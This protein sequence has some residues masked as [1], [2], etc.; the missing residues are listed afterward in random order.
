M[1]NAQTLRNHVR[2][3]FA[4][5]A[6][7][8]CHLQISHDLDAS[9]QRIDAHKLILARSPTLSRLINGATSASGSRMQLDVH[10]P[11]KYMSLHAFNECLKYIYGGQLPPLDPPYRQSFSF[12]EPAAAQ[13]ERMERALQR[14]AT[15]TWLEMPS[16]T[17][18]G[19]DVAINAM[20]W[21]TLPIALEFGL[22]G[23]LSPMWTLD[24]GS[25]ERGSTTSSDDSS[26]RTD[27]TP[28]M[29]AYDP[30][31]TQLLKVVLQYV[32]NSFP[33]DFYPDVSAP[34]LAVHPRLPP[35]PPLEP[36]NQNAQHEKNKL[37]RSAD[38]RLSQIRFGELPS[39]QDTPSRPSPLTTGI[40]S[41]LFSSPFPLLKFLLEHPLLAE[42]IGP[43]TVGSI[44]RQT[45]LERES[46]RLRCLK[47]KELSGDAAQDK[48][49]NSAELFWEESV[50]PTG[51]NRLGLR[52]CR[53]KKGV[54]TPPSS[55]EGTVNA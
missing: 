46:R 32:S 47:A 17:S 38:P 20:S 21:D 52:L 30:F 48:Q 12:V 33:S 13:V 4:K 37:S 34:Q 44:M 55:S 3:Q 53:K 50:E 36:K 25:E 28:S 23:G 7:A 54:E 43:E 49:H 24:D 1:D 16:I 8:D 40:S 14:I 31:A 11:G 22:E 45:I 6:F 26:S 35:L 15:G 10:L 18:R 41:L 9:T 42:R 5:P 27:P 29:P 2:A 39:E 19:M 51:Q